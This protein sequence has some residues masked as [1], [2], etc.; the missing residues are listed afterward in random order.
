[1]VSSSRRVGNLNLLCF[2][3]ISGKKL[4]DGRGISGRGRLTNV[5]IDTFECF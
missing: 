1:M 4:D 3:S 5:R 2:L